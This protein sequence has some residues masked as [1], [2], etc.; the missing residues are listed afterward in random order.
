MIDQEDLSNKKIKQTKYRVIDTCCNRNEK[1][2]LIF[3]TNKNQ[4]HK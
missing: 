3:G 2:E 4:K 1:G